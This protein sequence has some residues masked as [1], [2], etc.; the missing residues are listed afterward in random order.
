MGLVYLAVN[1]G[2]GGFSKLLVI[3]EL[4]PELVEDQGFLEMFLEEARLAA[5]L[6]HPNIVT[7][8]EVGI[9]SEG[10]QR[11]FIVMDYLE[12]QTLA[13]IIRKKSEMFSLNMHILIIAEALEGLHYAH[14]REDFDGSVMSVVHRDVSP[15]N[16]FVTYDGQ[17]KVV[18]FG[19]A[20]A[21]DTTVETRTGVFKGKP[22]YMAPE[23]LHGEVNPRS[24]VFSAGVMLWESLVG[25]RMWQKKSDVE[26]LT[27]L[28]KGQV[29]DIDEHAPEAPDELRAIV[30]K[31]L[32]MSV[33]DR[34]ESAKVLRDDLITFLAA[35]DLKPTVKEV[36]LVVAKI[37]AEQRTTLRNI[38][39]KCIAESK[40]GLPSR[41]KLPSI[42]PSN[43][44]G[45]GPSP[46]G[47]SSLSPTSS[48]EGS[49]PSVPAAAGS[50]RSGLT[51]R[52]D[53]G[54]IA[55]V[56]RIDSGALRLGESGPQS[57]TPFSGAT[58]AGAMIDNPLLEDSEFR[59]RK[60]SPLF[61]YAL[62]GGL[63]AAIL[64]LVV[65]LRLTSSGGTTTTSS[66]DPAGSGSGSSSAAAINAPPV[67]SP[68]PTPTATT[69]PTTS[70]TA[71]ASASAS[72]SASAVAVKTTPPPPPQPRFVYV[73]PPPP[74]PPKP[75]P[76]PPTKP[77]TVT[78][79]PIPTPTPASTKTDCNP[80][81]YYEGTKKVFKPGCI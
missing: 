24:D 31:A 9:D 19:I 13:R 32:A 20:K 10:I 66:V 64:A 25:R 44:E 4:K 23:Q 52:I 60:A 81:F 54:S 39:E 59:K 80:P 34:Y 35:R 42:A 21:S 40:A 15:Q 45:S 7:T 74:P 65:V 2:L 50:S 17:V 68:I 14:T 53:S 11:P 46:P 58:P 28:L 6:N 79:S 57:M 67:T 38:I 61:L 1:S 30:K 78:P 43:E 18:D 55:H 73:H 71:T 16:V 33:D 12:G 27:S 47:G 49:D 72:A 63:I 62:A 26:I 77:T 70:A 8:Y 51:Q 48:K 56:P 69:T 75:T 3:K 41:S 22:S 37:F 5:R 36:G 29:P 76:P